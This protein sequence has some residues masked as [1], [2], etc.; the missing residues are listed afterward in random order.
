[1]P[2]DEMTG[3]VVVVE[4]VVGKDGARVVRLHVDVGYLDYHRALWSLHERVTIRPL[5]EESSVSESHSPDGAEMPE[6]IDWLLCELIAGVAA[7][8][9]SLTLSPKAEAHRVELR[10]AILE[11]KRESDNAKADIAIYRQRSERAEDEMLSASRRALH[12]RIAELEEALRKAPL[13][14]GCGRPLDPS[15]TNIADGCPCNSPRGINHGLVPVN[16]CTCGRCDPAQTGSVRNPQSSPSSVSE[17]AT[18]ATCK[19][20]LPVGGA[21]AAI[22]LVTQLRAMRDVWQHDF[23]MYSLLH[24]AAKALERQSPQPTAGEA[25]DTRRLNALEG[26]VS[27][28]GLH[29]YRHRREAT[30]TS[31]AMDDQFMLSR[32]RSGRD[33]ATAWLPSLRAAVDSVAHL[34]DSQ[35]GRRK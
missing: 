18:A 22:T 20:S 12:A 13:C 6:K 27:D 30:A 14:R 25:E 8:G 29:I 24:D 3:T 26:L 15:A 17:G 11:L 1:M 9:L 31:P 5:P 16:V 4:G 34:L 33:F 10:S 23:E 19:E 28:A 32:N 2:D 21:T 35:D 7:S